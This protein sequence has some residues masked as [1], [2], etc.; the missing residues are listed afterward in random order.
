MLDNRAVIEMDKV[1][2]GYGAREV[3]HNVT[4][5][6]PRYSLTGIVGPN[7]GGKTTLLKLLL[8]LVQPRYGKVRV[9][10]QPPSVIRHR[11]G[12]VP[13]LF[14][15][16][17]RYPVSV[18]DVVLA[19]RVERHRFGFYRRS[20][21]IA[22]QKALERVDMQSRR[23]RS[24]AQL[25]GGERQRV[26]IAQALTTEPELL[27]LDEPTANV[28]TGAAHELHRLFTELS[29]ELTVL[30]VSHNHSVVAAHASH[31][32]CVNRTADLHLAKDMHPQRL[33][34]ASGD[35]LLI[36]QHAAS[37]QILDA[38]EKLRQPH[39]AIESQS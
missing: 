17:Q 11:I 36:I 20:D 10:G 29:K 5:G 37:C 39:A 33:Q 12:Y 27:F 38:T 23:N 32:L 18:N 1:C 26:L 34:T 24:F 35:E 7:G 8:G 14:N 31:I 9:L 21:R 19:G 22:A 25:S 30:M 4:F 16:D 15:F 6:L 3:L 2:F 13:Q 28:D